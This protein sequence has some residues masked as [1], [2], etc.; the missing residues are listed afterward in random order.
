VLMVNVGNLV[1][2]NDTVISVV[3]QVRPAYV[4][5]SVPERY[6]GAVR[7]KMKTDSLTVD[8]RIP[9][10]AGR[11]A[12][13]Q[14]TLVNNQVDLTTGTI[15]LRAECANDDEWLW[16]GAFVD[17]AVTLS[18]DKDVVV[19]PAEAIQFSQQ[20]R[21]IIVIKPDNTVE[22]R[23]VELGDSLAGEVVV[24][25]GLSGGEQVVTSGQLRLQNGSP[26]QIKN[27][28]I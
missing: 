3:N 6:L 20:G 18:V 16:P 21:Y 1:K 7:D 2:N 25:K 15:L 9:S 10:Q 27:E 8:V 28:H 24:K 13:G 14:L 4:D 5:F 26:V 22:F 11:N 12:Q 17:V 19:V 23:P